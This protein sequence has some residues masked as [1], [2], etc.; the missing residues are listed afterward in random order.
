MSKHSITLVRDGVVGH[1][2]QNRIGTDALNALAAIPGVE[3]SQIVQ[4]TEDRVELSYN[5]AR[6]DKFQAT[7]EHLLQFGLRR[8]D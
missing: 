6:D 5:W 2:S 8:I 1:Q 3:D 7:R 4:E